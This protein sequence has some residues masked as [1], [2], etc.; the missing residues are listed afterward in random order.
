MA[1]NAAALDELPED[2]AQRLTSELTLENL[3]SLFTKPLY[4]EVFARTLVVGGSG[5]D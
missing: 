2:Q 5:P 4:L 3:S 1:P